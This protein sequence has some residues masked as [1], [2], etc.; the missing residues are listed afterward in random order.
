[1]P[2]GQTADE[3]LLADGKEKIA[4]AKGKTASD[5][6]AKCTASPPTFGI[7]AGSAAA[8][9][10]AVARDNSLSLLA[11]IFGA[12]LTNAVVN[13]DD[14]QD[15]CKCQQAVSKDYQKLAA[16]KFKEFLKCKKAVLKG[17]A[18][19][20]GD[21]E[22]CVDDPGT[23]GSIVDD[24]KGKIAKARTKLGD[25][26][27]AKCDTPGVNTVR[28]LPGACA[29]L[30][31]T[32]L[33]DCID[34]RVECR[35]CLTINAMDDLDVDC[36]TFDDGQLNLS[37]PRETFNL[38]SLAEAPNT[39]GTTGVAVTNPNLVT[40]FG[41]SFSLNNVR[42]TR[43]RLSESTTEPD[44]ILILIPGFE[45]GANDFKI[46]AENLIPK[47][48]AD[49]GVVLEV[50]A[51]D[52]RTNQL[53]DTLGLDI[54]E[55]QNDAQIGLDWLFGTE[56]ALSLHPA[57]VA[58]PN[59]R[60]VFHNAQADVPFIANWT[61][62]L[63][64]RDI[65]AIVEKARTIADNGNVFLGGHSAGTGF[66]ARYAATDF[67]LTGSGPADPGYA[68]LRGLVLLEGTAGST[69][70]APLTADTLDRIEAKFDG[71]LFAAVRD[72]AGRCVDGTTACTIANEATTCA[73]QTPP[74]C[75][76]ATFAYSIVPGL[77][78]PRILAAVEP[79]AIQGVSDPDSGQIILRVDQGSAGNNAI[80]KVP[81][82]ATLAL[83]PQST[84]Y[85]GI[86]SFIDDDGFIAAA[87]SF[88]A[89]SV[90]APGPVVSGLT[91]WLDITEGPMPP[92]ALPNNGAPPTSLPAPV[93]GQEK[94]VTRFE[95]MITTF[96]AGQSNFTDWYYPA[97]GL[98]VTSVTGLCTT[99]TC[100]VGNVGAS[101]STN[102]DCSQSISLD[103]T[104][105]SVGRG[106]WDIENL[107][108]AANIVIPVIGFG[109]SNG[110]ARVPGSF[111]AFGQSIGLCAAPSCNGSTARVVDPSNPST[112][113]PTLG[114]IDG[115]FEV[116][117]SEG[118]AH[119]DV[120][121][122][123]DNADNNVLAPLAAFLARNI[124]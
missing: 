97:S 52:R 9:V 40:Q 56:L 32:A 107:T 106:R 84:V 16:A 44:A 122:A 49:E 68:K 79:A 31:G 100:T 69:S 78:N 2:S 91:T 70:G 120:T 5:F 102:G 96:F 121:T 58:G 51:Y 11:D 38:R 8:V 86:G 57:L 89:T 83:L 99:G 116:Y 35:V 77:L 13:C 76:P 53:E 45:G 34:E 43:Y 24:A 61:P 65:D 119:V 74:K 103:S 36:D 15:A 85:G 82:L 94:E 108:Q 37:C 110:L 12:S 46:L 17:G 101:C 60:A 73:G 4:A 42:Y 92:A 87:A 111:V 3:C 28:A 109:G 95:R 112:A 1:M 90:G 33:R 10:N 22:D 81:D 63:F 25:D 47:V 88:V 114:D 75:T 27:D 117:I 80:A 41:P 118:F 115:G 30:T 54:A 18:S 23:P 93:W 113:F 7:P 123:E 55:A 29:G 72:N 39:P 104:P 71:G 26:I 64:S 20:A 124:Q 59:R 50:W 62:L 98:S 14:D 66:T 48:L 105:L 6:A 21:L 19:S 67:N